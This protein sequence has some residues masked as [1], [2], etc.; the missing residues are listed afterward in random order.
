MRTLIVAIAFAAGLVASTAAAQLPLT[1]QAGNLLTWRGE[2][3]AK[4]FR[5]IERLY[6]TETVKRGPSVRP[7]PLAE[8]QIAPAGIDDY[9]REHRV[10]GLLAIKDGKIVLEKYAL[11]RTLQDRWT[12]FSVAK[13]ITSTLVGAAVQDGSIKSLDEPVSRYVEGLKGSAYDGASI[14]QLL[15]MSSGVK[16]NE[17]YADP[18]SDVARSSQSPA[19]GKLNPIVAYLARLPREHPAG[20]RFHYNTGETDLVGIL[21]SQATGKSLSQYLSEKVWGPFGMEQDAIWMVDQSGHERG[22]CCISM[23]LRDY[24]R[25][26]LFMLEDGVAGGRRVLPPGWVS[27]AT[28][29]QIKAG[30]PALGYGYF[31]W[32]QPHGYAAE[33]IFGQAIYVFPDDKLVVV[34]NSAWP[35]ADADASWAAQARVAEGVRRAAAAR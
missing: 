9:M 19:D 34:F 5:D 31:W 18:N 33:G 26:G 24:G 25:F 2:E 6:K 22:G 15:T 21:V 32:M 3:Q 28:T 11:G 8:R 20:A 23:T 1:E 14:R 4:A 29:A 17:D 16:W 7:L 35:E 13:S 12:S 30:A 10:S 27:Q